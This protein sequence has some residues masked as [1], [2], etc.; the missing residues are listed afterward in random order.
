MLE[1]F[2]NKFVSRLQNYAQAIIPVCES[3]KILENTTSEY[4]SLKHGMAEIF[5]F[6]FVVFIFPIFLK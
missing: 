2:R 1:I 3:K 5:I 6:S 4:L